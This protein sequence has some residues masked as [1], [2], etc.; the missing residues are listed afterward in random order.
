MT[1]EQTLQA[2][3]NAAQTQFK[4]LRPGKVVARSM[5]TLDNLRQV[6][7]LDWRSITEMFNEAM[8]RVGGTELK[9]ATLCR[10]YNL[11]LKRLMLIEAT[12][13][14]FAEAATASR[15]DVSAR[16]AYRATREHS[17]AGT[18]YR[19]QTNQV[20]DGPAHN[21]AAGTQHG[22]PS[23]R[24]TVRLQ[25]EINEFTQEAKRKI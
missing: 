18:A 21:H 4:V 2:F 1:R 3:I 5:S 25:R 11:Q 13:G 19:E 9:S 12:R 24:E 14:G 17:G 23:A 20:R 7:A 10:L 6:Q 8:T 22:P 16:G 15:H